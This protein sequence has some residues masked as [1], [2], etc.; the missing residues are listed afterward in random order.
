MMERLRLMEAQFV[1]GGKLRADESAKHEEELNKMASEREKQR[2]IYRQEMERKMKEEKDLVEK[3]VTLQQSVNEKNQQVAQ[4]WK[5]LKASKAEQQEIEQRLEQERQEHM[6]VMRTMMESE[7]QREK[8]LKEKE[9]IIN[10]FIPSDYIRKIISKLYYDDE[11][12][13]FS[14]IETGRA[15]RPQIPPQLNLFG[16]NGMNYGQ[17][18]TGQGQQGSQLMMSTTM[19]M[20]QQYAQMIN[21]R[22]Q[23]NNGSNIFGGR[24]LD[25]SRRVSVESIIG[26]QSSKNG[27]VYGQSDNTPSPPFESSVFS[28]PPFPYN[29]QQ[30][31]SLSNTTTSAGL[32]M[33]IQKPGAIGGSTGRSGQDMNQSLTKSDKEKDNN[34]RGIQNR[35]VQPQKLPKINQWM[36]N[37]QSQYKKAQ[38]TSGSKQDYSDED[39]TGADDLD[40]Y[41]YE[42]IELVTENEIN[43]QG[44]DQDGVSKRFIRKKKKKTEEEIES[45]MTDHQREVKQKMK[46]LL[47]KERKESDKQW[48]QPLSLG[49]GFV[50]AA[51]PSSLSSSYSQQKI[52]SKAQSQNPNQFYPQSKA[53]IS[54]KRPSPITS[55]IINGISPKQNISSINGS[56]DKKPGSGKVIIKSKALRKDENTSSSGSI[57]RPPSA[58][59]SLHQG[60]LYPDYQTNIQGSELSTSHSRHSPKIINTS[61]PSKPVTPN[62]T[63]NQQL[64]QSP[65]QNSQQYPQSKTSQMGSPSIINAQIKKPKRSNSP[66]KPPLPVSPSLHT[67]SQEQF[68]LSSTSIPASFADAAAQNAAGT[69]QRTK[70]AS[71][72][73]RADSAGST[74]QKSVPNSSTSFPQSQQ[75]HPQ[76]LAGQDSS[77]PKAKGL[78]K[79]NYP[80]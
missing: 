45:E 62:P 55:P 1:E 26:S 18:R 2:E 47:E 19:N 79:P 40:E 72:T 61:F 21:D 80:K 37:E 22:A 16:Q 8:K 69:K 59:Q 53:S 66:S 78:A 43:Q 65:I 51:A 7:K 29:N 6:D 46:E 41:E 10:S 20:S 14:L 75:L 50:F 9:F 4:L 63:L 58:S 25:D 36:N 49:S 70:P 23:Q 48:F 74:G 27:Q 32:V 34:K 44:Y 42:W 76:I 60:L 15:G 67:E 39:W 71:P 54:H 28:S 52:N 24:S 68:P 73:S 3:Q 38:F 77:F 64:F 11:T 57:N 13:E 30:Q 31:Q 17:G 56:G 5:D 12:E 33:T 35:V